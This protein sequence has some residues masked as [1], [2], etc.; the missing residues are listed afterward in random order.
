MRSPLFRGR[1]PQAPG[2]PIFTIAPWRPEYGDPRHPRELVGVATDELIRVRADAPGA[3]LA[4]A[5]G[6]YAITGRVLVVGHARQLKRYARLQAGRSDSEAERRWLRE[7]K[8][9]LA[10]RS[11]RPL[12][13]ARADGLGHARKRSASR[14]VIA[15]RNPDKVRRLPRAPRTNGQAP[16][17]QGKL[18][19]TSDDGA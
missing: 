14:Q 2:S 1:R 8:D 13:L 3:L 12:R 6:R 11:P 10:G 18:G 9:E 4:L 15:R 5:D 16:G 17:R 19:P 7:V